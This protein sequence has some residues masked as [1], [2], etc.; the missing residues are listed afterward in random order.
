[1][2]TKFL[3]KALAAT[4]VPRGGTGVGGGTALSTQVPDIRL[5]IQIPRKQP[6]A[7]R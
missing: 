4:P 3:D 1:M 2:F 6:F 7:R 5:A